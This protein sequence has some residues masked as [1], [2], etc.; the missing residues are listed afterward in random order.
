MR[1]FTMGD[2]IRYLV[3]VHFV[4][5]KSNNFFLFYYALVATTILLLVSFFILPK[6]Q[7]I[8]N[9][10]L[11]APVVFYLW[12]HALNPDF[13][14]APKWSPRLGA[15]IMVFSLLGIFSYFMFMKLPN[16]ISSTPDTALQE[17]NQTNVSDIEL[18]NYLEKQIG[19]LSTKID[20]LGKRD[21]NT[22]GI[23]L[24]Q[25]SPLP[26]SALGQI[27][28]KDSNLT[29]IAIYETESQNSKVV[30]SAKYEAI[31]PYYQKNSSWYKIEEGWV[32]ARWFTEVSP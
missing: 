19:I 31:Y 26:E 10:I 2:C 24:E 29:D 16:Y 6:P 21:L 12:T 1:L 4:G 28:V 32:Q 17:A 30:G 22:L 18:K 5:M 15:I 27:T 25:S 20:S 23:T 14:E 7:N 9:T 13:F 11:L 8:L 3:Y